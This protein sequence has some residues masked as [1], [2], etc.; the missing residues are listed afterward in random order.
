MLTLQCRGPRWSLCALPTDSPSAATQ[1][2]RGT[3]LVLTFRLRAASCFGSKTLKAALLDASTARTRRKH[4]M[5]PACMVQYSM[6]VVVVCFCVLA[7]TQHLPTLPH[8]PD[9]PTPLGWAMPCSLA[10]EN[11]RPRTT[12]YGLPRDTLPSPLPPSRF[13]LPL[14]TPRF[15]LMNTFNQQ[16]QRMHVW[17]AG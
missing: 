3:A 16:M 1:L 9:T 11:S 6:A 14:H 4:C 5:V 10:L 12:R 2:Q 8:V 13:K 15:R 17:A 7:I